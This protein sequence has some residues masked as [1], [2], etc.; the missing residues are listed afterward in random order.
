MW[1]TLSNVMSSSHL[2]FW[3]FFIW[4]NFKSDFVV[5][6]HIEDSPTRK[7]SGNF[8][9]ESSCSPVVSIP[10]LSFPWVKFGQKF[11]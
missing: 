6:I 10:V 1:V 4:F 7:S 2:S 9:W 8:L 3:I 11:A 5:L